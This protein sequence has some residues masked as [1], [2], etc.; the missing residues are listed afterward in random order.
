MK[1]T[2]TTSDLYLVVHKV[3][4][5]SE[6]KNYIKLKATI[7]YKSNDEVCYW[8]NPLGRAKTFK[9]DLN[10]YN[11]FVKYEVNSNK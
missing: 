9:L 4:H 3:Y 11:S 5:I 10:T 2:P 1:L 7:K 8:L 6:E